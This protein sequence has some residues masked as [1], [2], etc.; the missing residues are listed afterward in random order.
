MAN[1]IAQST[2]WMP[3]F[4]DAYR[5]ASLTAVLDS[6]TDMVSWTNDGYKLEIP[7][8][9]L[10]GMADYSRST[11]YVNGDITVAPQ[12]VSPNYERGRKFVIDKLDVD[13]A[14]REFS[15][16]TG[17]F[18]RQQYVPELD[19]FRIAKIAGTSGIGTASVTQTAFSELTGADA[20]A[21]LRAAVTAMDNA[22]TPDNERILFIRPGIIG[23]I[24]DLNT[25]ASRAVLSHFTQIVRVPPSRMYTAVTLT[26]SGGYAGTGYLNFLAVAKSA[27]IQVQKHIAP[28]IITPDANQTA[29]AW[30]FGFR[31]T[32]YEAVYGN[33]LAGVYAHT[34]TI[35]S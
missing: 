35:S 6:P 18:I 5:L 19:A 33:K 14:F 20:I 8:M 28:K 26:S 12:I 34:T 29:D 4:D 31:S 15:K 27:V 22:E 25:D 1:S 30:L 23:N 3:L 10:P 21:A 2:K 11:G 24:E 32:G 9:T 16:A 7:N 17:E 13:E